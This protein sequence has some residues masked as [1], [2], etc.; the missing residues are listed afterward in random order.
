M[1]RVFML[2]CFAIPIC[3]YSTQCNSV[4]LWQINFDFNIFFVGYM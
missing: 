4:A 3:P 2:N 1:K